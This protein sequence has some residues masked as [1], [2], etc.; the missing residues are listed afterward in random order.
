M[1]N[2]IHKKMQT[3]LENIYEKHFLGVEDPVLGIKYSFSELLYSPDEVFDGT[4]DIFEILNHLQD[5]KIIKDYD[6][7]KG[8]EACFIDF[9]IDFRVIAR[10]YIKELVVDEV[11][12]LGSSSISILYFDSNGNLWHG[13]DKKKYCYSVDVNSNRFQILK[14]LVENK[15]YQ[16]PVGM[17]PHLKTKT[18]KTLRSE[19]HRIRENITKFLEIDGKEII[20]AKEDSGYRIN[21]KYKIMLM[22]D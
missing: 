10:K 11:T 8:Q 3:V 22:K 16:A 6:P 7:I 9:P 1:I 2:K 15:G 13:G 19:I 12:S 20:D 5:K 17:L 14:Y 21:P 18:T 4:E